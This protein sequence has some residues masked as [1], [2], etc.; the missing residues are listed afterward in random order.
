MLLA[1]K[2]LVILPSSMHIIIELL[3]I[4]L[5]CL[6]I[7]SSPRSVCLS[8]LYG[9]HWRLGITLAMQIE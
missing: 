5:K 4:T 7:S 3:Q 8:L 9:C 2:S 1:L 6:H